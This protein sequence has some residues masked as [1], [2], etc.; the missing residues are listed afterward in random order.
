MRSDYLAQ[1][2][3]WEQ[4]RDREAHLFDLQQEELLVE[5][6]QPHAT[7]WPTTPRLQA[8]PDDA[9]QDVDEIAQM[10]E[11]EL[12][13]I[14][15]MQAAHAQ[16]QEADEAM[17]MSFQQS[18]GREQAFDI[19]SSPTRYG[20]DDEDYDDIFMEL[21]SSQQAIRG[22]ARVLSQPQDAEMMDM[23]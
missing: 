16:A 6:E 22:A 1:R 4:E 3:R 9:T 17:H 19:P 5:E 23:T 15:E 13:A 10:E 14:L 7:S 20:S 12:R 18:Q 11:E 8:Q 21:L 2:R